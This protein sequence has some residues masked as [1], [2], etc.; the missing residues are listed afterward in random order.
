MNFNF[1]FKRSLSG[2]QQCA[3]AFL[4]HVHGNVH[5]KWIDRDGHILVQPVMMNACLKQICFFYFLV[6]VETPRHQSWKVKI[7]IR[8]LASLKYHRR[9]L[10]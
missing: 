7:T 8:L 4:L 1:N 5:R 3:S 6:D 9:T 10:V 2:L